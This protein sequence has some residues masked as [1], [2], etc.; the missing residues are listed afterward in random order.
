VPVEIRI[1][2]RSNCPDAPKWRVHV[3]S[4]AEGALQVV[5]SVLDIADPG[6][7]PAYTGYHDGEVFNDGFEPMDLKE[8]LSD[9]G[10]KP[11]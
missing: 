8:S 10:M 9:V 2:F 7:S 1:A 6:S 11:E 3:S 4:S 5:E